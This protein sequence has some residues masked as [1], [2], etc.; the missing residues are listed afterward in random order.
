MSFAGDRVR[1][2]LQGSHML[3]ARKCLLN[4]VEERQN[5][6]CGV[7]RSRVIWL[8]CFLLAPGLA[9][10]CGFWNFLANLRGNVSAEVIYH[11]VDPAACLRRTLT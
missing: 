7:C 2:R 9:P 6:R 11:T 3:V 4:E 8:N 1:V 5:Q 10:G